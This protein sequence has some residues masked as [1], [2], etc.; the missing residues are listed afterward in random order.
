MVAD[1]GGTCTVDDKRREHEV[2]SDT[3]EVTSVAEDV[4]ETKEDRYGAACAKERVH[5]QLAAVT[6]R[7]VSLAVS[8]SLCEQAMG[9]QLEMNSFELLLLLLVL[10]VD[11]V[12]DRHNVA[13]LLVAEILQ[14]TD[15][16][17]APPGLLPF[18]KLSQ[19]LHARMQH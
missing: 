5:E 19:R 9:I 10:A 4:V 8:L 15:H 12:L 2:V 1:G 17:S 14:V 3:S 7:G 6:E 16:I 13:L 11:E 18:Q